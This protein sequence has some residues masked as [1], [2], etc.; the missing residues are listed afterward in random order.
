M[1][2]LRILLFL[3]FLFSLAGCWDREELENLGL[4]LAM[5]ID[6]LPNREVE[7]TVQV[8]IPIRLGPGGGGGGGAA[9]GEKGPPTQVVTKKA[10]T[11]PEAFRAINRTLCRRITLAQSRLLVFGEETARKGLAPYLALF[12][13]Y[14]EFRRT[15]QIAVVKGRA[16]EI[17]SLQPELEKN[18][19]EYLLD[20][21]RQ[22]RHTGG[23]DLVTVNEFLRAMSQHGSSPLAPY[24]LLPSPKPSSGG[25]EGGEG[26]GEKKGPKSV[27]TDGVAVFRGDRMIG[28]Y[29]PAEVDALLM[30]AGRF[31]ESFLSFQDPLRPADRVVLH[32]KSAVRQIRP[33]LHGRKMGV[34]VRMKIEADLVADES[35]IDYTIPQHEERLQR[36]AAAII[37]ARLK[38]AVKKAQKELKV[39]P[40]GFGER[41]RLLVPDWRAWE[42]LRWQERFP[43][44][45]VEI[46]V[47]LH[48]RRFGFQRLAPRP[49]IF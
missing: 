6:S 7:V 31:G 46:V 37:A 13:R 5:G 32:L 19:T 16:K 2:G 43:R 4:V 27:E 36:K 14:R 11:V 48:L 12:V 1:R 28:R 20:L 24:L 41:F 3:F 22:A 18:P 45:P 15:M 42:G 33:S 34:R 21:I 44:L 10:K 38:K 23:T 17:L 9:G 35:G 26:G 30:L 29:R 8:A 47:D 39:D 25:K 40:F 49:V